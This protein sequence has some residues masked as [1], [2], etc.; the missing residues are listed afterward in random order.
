MWNRNCL[1]FQ[2]TCFHPRCLVGFVLLVLY[3][4]VYCF[5]NHFFFRFVF[6]LLAIVLCVLL[7]FKACDYPF[8]IVKISLFMTRSSFHILSYS[9]SVE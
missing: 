9:R 2:S 5:V 7:R 4:F 1:S 6:F 3:L 8:V